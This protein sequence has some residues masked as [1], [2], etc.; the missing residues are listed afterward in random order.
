MTTIIDQISASFIEQASGDYF[1]MEFA[2]IQ[3]LRD[4]CDVHEHA[5]TCTLFLLNGCAFQSLEDYDHCI[6][7]GQDAQHDEF[8]SLNYPVES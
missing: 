2:S 7:Y 1:A 8:Y 6:E 3:Y 4:Y 5:V